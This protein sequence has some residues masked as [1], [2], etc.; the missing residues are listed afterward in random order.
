VKSARVA[1][2]RR[3]H[4]PRVGY[5]LYYR[6]ARRARRVE[7]LAFWHAKRGAGPPIG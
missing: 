4:L 3:V 7:I 5:H 2:V 1:G 6:V